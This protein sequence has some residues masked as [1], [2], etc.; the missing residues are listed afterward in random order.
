VHEA[1]HARLVRLP[2]GP[3]QMLSV[4]VPQDLYFAVMRTN[5]SRHAGRGRP[6]DS[7]SWL[8]AREFCERLGWML[9][10]RVRLPTEVEFRAA[11][12]RSTADGA[13]ELVA[14]AWSSENAEGRSHD[15]GQSPRGPVGCFDLAGNLA[16]WLEAGASDSAAVA[17]GSYLDASA[18]LRR[19]PIVSADKRER[20]RHIGFRV[21]VEWP[22]N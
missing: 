13:A 3:A 9:G 8:D 10:G 20:A 22:A 14:G 4:E 6:V 12:G 17:G 16:E 7:V 2:S 19:V 15:V 11:F 5:P 1:V 18:D 21:V